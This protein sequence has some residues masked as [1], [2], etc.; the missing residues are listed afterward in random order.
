MLFSDL[1]RVG[2]I[3]VASP[4]S[5]KPTWTNQSG[6]KYLSIFSPDHDEVGVQDRD[7][8]EEVGG[9]GGQRQEREQEFL[10][11]ERGDAGGGVTGDAPPD[12]QTWC[13]IQ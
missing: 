3:I 4:V 10:L 7:V 11:A 9:G 8:E 5:G 12:T 2:V 13:Y 6:L 1:A